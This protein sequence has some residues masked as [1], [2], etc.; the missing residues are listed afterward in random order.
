M[1]VALFIGS[2]L[3][4]VVSCIDSCAVHMQTSQ[5]NVPQHVRPTTPPGHGGQSLGFA[6]A[7]GVTI[8][9]VGDSNDYVGK[10]LSGTL[11][12]LTL[13]HPFVCL[14]LREKGGGKSR[15]GYECCM[16]TSVC[17]SLR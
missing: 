14:F 8:E 9:V 13:W 5:Q 3:C 15:D 4:R 17:F 16:L 11:F 7:A 6:L 2:W 12:F 10:G 1:Y